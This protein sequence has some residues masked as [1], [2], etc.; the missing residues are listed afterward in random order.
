[1]LDL[2]FD[3]PSGTRLGLQVVLNL[4]PLSHLATILNYSVP[5]HEYFQPSS[6][7]LMAAPPSG[8]MTTFQLLSNRP[9]FIAVCSVP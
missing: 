4:Q 3:S 2:T 1:M 8:H 5:P 9:A 6:E 7:V